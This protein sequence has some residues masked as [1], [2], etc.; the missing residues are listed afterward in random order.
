MWL[1]ITFR[2]SKT[3]VHHVKNIP[4]LYPIYDILRIS[5][6]KEDRMFYRLRSQENKNIEFK[7]PK[8]DFTI[9]KSDTMLLETD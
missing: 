4:Y 7:Y 2:M 9:S 8:L 1:G 3:F 5:N 6:E